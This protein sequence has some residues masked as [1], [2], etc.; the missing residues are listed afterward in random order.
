MMLKKREE[1]LI[2]RLAEQLTGSSQ[3]GARRKTVLTQNVLRRM[4]A[5]GARSLEAYLGVVET[6]EREYRQLISALTIHY[7]RWF[8]EAE[9]FDAILDEITK[10]PSR[11]QGAP[12][13]FLCA[14]C[15]TGEEVYSLALFLERQRQLGRIGEYTVVGIDIDSVSIA[16]ATRAIY[17][18]RKM[19]DIPSV[20]RASVLVG[21]GRAEGLFTIA[22]EIRRRCKFLC[23]D[24]RETRSLLTAAGYEQM[25]VSICRNVLIYF[26]DS[27]IAA[28]VE[29]LR[30]CV[31]PRGLVCLGHSETIEANRFRLEPRGRAI[32]RVPGVTSQSSAA[33]PR[34]KAL[35]VDDSMVVRRVLTSLLS[36]VGMDAEA[37]DSAPAATSYL[38][39]T[40]VDLIT[41]DLHMPGQDGATWL[42]EQRRL[43]LKTPT[44]VVS[45]STPEQAEEM[46]GVLAGGAQ[47]F[48][49]KAE[50]N[51]APEALAQRLQAIARHAKTGA[52]HRPQP[53]VGATPAKGPTRFRPDLILIGASTGGTNAL[54]SMLAALPPSCPPLLIVQHITP[55]FAETFAQ[56]LARV[57]NLKL[58][59]PAQ[60]DELLPGH[61]YMAL[62]DHHIG[63]RRTGGALRIELSGAPPEHSIRPAVDFLFRSAAAAKARCLAALL[64]GMGSDGALGLV[65]LKV[66]GSLT[67][68]QNEASCVVFGMPREAIQLG[69]ATIIGDLRELRLAID[70]CLAM[71]HANA[72]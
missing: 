1:E 34:L 38:R 19:A 40:T 66:A 16:H 28:V 64:T 55:A 62:G 52:I 44:V 31:R 18:C 21:N 42:A 24:L 9:H 35:V 8:R 7:T 15:S 45:D 13:S 57:A 69:A 4:E 63:V 37:V 67:M 33:S 56:R 49:T 50:L 26:D 27:G 32:Y 29:Q 20:H 53:P 3:H 30:S 17:D 22:P 10:D 5:V 23:G 61:L 11:P 14:A 47:D 60:G 48:I 65:D 12:L 68:A 25:D 70:R 41:L 39:S 2:Y 43:G 51:A 46:F 54:V 71:P 59:R 58:A 6:D 72:S 36:R